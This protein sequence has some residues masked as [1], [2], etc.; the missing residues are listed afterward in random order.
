[1]RGTTGCQT[2][3]GDWRPPW[4]LSDNGSSSPVPPSLFNLSDRVAVVIGGTSGIGRTLAVGLAEA[5]ADVVVTGRRQ[6]LVDEVAADVEALG[7]RTLR[8]ALG[9]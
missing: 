9:N 7:R 6:P 1:M 8:L 2:F 4:C 5:G 3:T